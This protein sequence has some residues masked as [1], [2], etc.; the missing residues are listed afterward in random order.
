MAER[1]PLYLAIDIGTGSVRVALFNDKGEKLSYS[2]GKIKT[3]NPRL[4]HYEQSTVNIWRSTVR[5]IQHV[6]NE[7]G[8]NSQA[9]KRYIASIGVDATCSLAVCL[10]NGLLTPVP[11]DGSVDTEVDDSGI[12][13]D[14]VFNVILWMDRRSIVDTNFINDL[15]ERNDHV[16]DVLSHFGGIMSPE[17]Q[18][19]KIRW[20]CR[21]YP[22]RFRGNDI[23]YF[24]LSDWL[25]AKLTACV[26]I[27][28]RSTC[29]IACKWGWHNHQWNTQF[30]D[31]LGLSHL[32]GDDFRAIGKPDMACYPGSY[33]GDLSD[34]V[35]AELSFR[36]SEQC[37]VAAG[38]IDAYSG[39][40]W[41]LGLAHLDSN[42]EIDKRKVVSF[43]CGT[44]TCVL[45][46][47]ENPVFV[48]GVWGPHQHA[49]IP[50]WHVTEGGQT[51]TGKLLDHLVHTHPAFAELC[52]LYI[53]DE[54][55]IFQVL[56]AEGEI[57]F[58]TYGED[59]ATHVH[60]LDY[61]SGNRSPIADAS[62]R[63]VHT[64]LSLDTSVA[65][66]AVQFRAAVQAL[67]Y[68]GK[69]ILDALSNAGLPKACVIAACGGLTRCDLFLTELADCVGTPVALCE[70]VD[71]VLL[72]GA[73]LAR[74]AHERSDDM[75]G[76]AKQMCRINR[77]INPNPDRKS[78]HDRKY[79]VY[80]KMYEDFVTYRSIMD[81]I[82]EEGEKN[83]KHV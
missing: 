11:L 30:W 14:D 56:S 27:H 36:Q 76:I 20:L 49:L 15:G 22:K 26:N 52:E 3:R 13:D 71:T 4:D 77:V 29:T 16:K 17:N 72:G 66:L 31:A 21:N 8:L 6:A 69:R 47:S 51:I 63:G 80:K 46:V 62:A 43:V 1:Q 45:Q 18:P 42:D 70:E 37:I 57:Q 7:C 82:G 65:N 9:A 32:C 39:S 41:A 55:T 25:V 73:V 54:N 58:E 75:M 40:I 10:D 2:S 33:V 60:L 61:Y 12:E 19:P 44:S 28:A 34:K 64:G 24:D 59:P 78:Y 48:P 50:N 5:C 23:V 83:D 79:K 53:N 81:G 68:G 38:I 74:M 67:C 35:G